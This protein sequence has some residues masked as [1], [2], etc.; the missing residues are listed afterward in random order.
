MRKSEVYALGMLG[1]PWRLK[2]EPI[3][4]PKQPIDIALFSKELLES[5][6]RLAHRIGPAHHW[7]ESYGGSSR[8]LTGTFLAV[9]TPNR[10]GPPPGRHVSPDH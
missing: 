9:L 6:S 10:S 7:T 2:W 1:C 3:I 5:K 4:A 8:I